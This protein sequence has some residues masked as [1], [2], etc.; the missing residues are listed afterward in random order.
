MNT[1]VNGSIGNRVGTI[2]SYYRLEDVHNLVRKG[3][4]F[5]HFLHIF[6]IKLCLRKLEIR[7]ERFE[8]I[9]YDFLKT[10]KL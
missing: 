8:L 10:L 6:K 3:I 2:L 9:T 1:H 5:L 4:F 7:T